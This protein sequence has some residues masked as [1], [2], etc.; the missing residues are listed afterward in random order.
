MLE[1]VIDIMDSLGY[2]GVVLLMF[3]ENVFPPIP[4][5]L[6]MPLAG[7]TAAQGRLSLVGVIIAGTL[8]SVIGGLPLY[9]LGRSIGEQRLTSWAEQYGTWLSV[10]ANEI[11]IAKGWFDRHGSKAVFFCRLVPGIRS[12]IS[13]PA[14]LASMN[15][16]H[17]LLYSTLG[18][19]IWTSVLAYVGYL[20]GE[21]YQQVNKYLGPAPFFVLG[22]LLVG[23]AAWVWR[24]R[25]Q[26]SG[27]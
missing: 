4:S 22:L 2:P 26:Q 27:E 20:L 8:G 13:I 11:R 19:G 17:Y 18:A 21:N 5:E 1:R 24:R 16:L 6:V 3:L 9:Y 10:S 7:F 12:L 23:F 15:M 14:G 25:Q